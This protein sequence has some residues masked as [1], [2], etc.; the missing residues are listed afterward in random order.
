[1][2]LL[3]IFWTYLVEALSGRSEENTC[4]SLRA[5]QLTRFGIT[6]PNLSSRWQADRNIDA[7][8]RTLGSKLKD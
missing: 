6:L 4:L 2:A 3:K 5:E 7:N 1:M 8:E